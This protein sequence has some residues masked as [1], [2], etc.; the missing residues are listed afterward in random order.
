MLDRPSPFGSNGSSPISAGTSRRVAAGIRT[1]AYERSNSHAS[2]L[3]WNV[4]TPRSSPAADSTQPRVCK[5]TRSTEIAQAL[6]HRSMLIEAANENAQ[7]PGAQ[8]PQPSRMA[9]ATAIWTPSA[10]PVRAARLVS[11]SSSARVGVGIG[12]QAHR[13]SECSC[14]SSIS[15]ASV[16]VGRGTLCRAGTEKSF[17]C[18]SDG[19]IA[20]ATGAIDLQS[21][22]ITADARRQRSARKMVSSSPG[23]LTS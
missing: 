20:A 10:A 11:G 23:Y 3:L 14:S 9:A 13:S 6:W 5:Y 12:T 4:W 8:Q 22:R 16:T 19:F 15:S 21:S 1:A 17:R 7:V 2:P 18:S